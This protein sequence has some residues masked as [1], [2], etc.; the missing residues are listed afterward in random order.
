MRVAELE[1][2]LLQRE[3]ELEIVKVCEPGNETLRLCQE[4]APLFDLQQWASNRGT[5][6]FLGS[7]RST[8]C[9]TLPIVCCSVQLHAVECYR[10]HTWFI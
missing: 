6:E 2:Q 3:K 7:L 5:L 10:T 8:A 4:R 1:K 9:D